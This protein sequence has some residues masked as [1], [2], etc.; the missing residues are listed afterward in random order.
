MDSILRIFYGTMVLP[1]RQVH[2]IKL[3]EFDFWISGNF[4]RNFEKS[5]KKFEKVKKYKKKVNFFLLQGNC[6]KLVPSQKMIKNRPVHF[7]FLRE[8]PKMYKLR[9]FC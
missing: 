3:P 2:S 5:E 6:R 1:C 4:S 8:I 7:R 9:E